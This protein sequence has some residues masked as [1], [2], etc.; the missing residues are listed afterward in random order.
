MKK[1]IIAGIT[2]QDGSLLYDYLKSKKFKVIGLSRKRHKEKHIF[3]TDYSLQSLSR[4]INLF[5]PDEIYN[6]SGLSNPSASWEKIKETLEA[7]LY[8]TVN[9]L[10][11]IKKKKK[12]KYFNSSSSEIFKD[13]KNKLNENSSIYPINPYGVAKASSH[14]L[15]DAYRRKYNLFLING[16]FFNHSSLK[17][18]NDFLLKYLSLQF[19]KLKNNKI[20]KINIMDSRPVRDFGYAKDYIIYAYKLMQLKKSDNFIIATGRSKSVKQIVNVYLKFYNLPFKKINYKN[21]NNFKNLNKYKKA[22][23]TKILSALKIKKMTSINQVI[24]KIIKSEV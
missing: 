5:K 21:K 24:K 17:T 6:F 12:I 2:G 8:I 7:N 15:V 14:F 16:I 1:I 11:I 18:N 13:S 23:N 10:E 20:K 9:F 3:K 22:N 4:L 19:K